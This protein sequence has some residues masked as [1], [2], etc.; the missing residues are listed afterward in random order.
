MTA[1]IEYLT[2]LLKYIDLFGAP[3]EWCPGQNS[4]VA[5]LLAA[6]AIATTYCSDIAVIIKYVHVI[7]VIDS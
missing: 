3:A 7:V 2:V 4:P 1:L 5:P 6:L